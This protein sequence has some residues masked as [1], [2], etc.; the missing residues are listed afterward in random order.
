M[1]LTE[2]LQ[3]KIKEEGPI[4][5]LDFMDM[6]LYYPSLGYYN[7]PAN[8]IGKEGDYYTSP[9]LSS[10]FGEIVAKQLEE[11]WFLLDKKPFTI[12]EYGAG[13]GALCSDILQYLQ[14]NPALF[15]ELKYCIIEKSESMKLQQQKMFPEKVSW[16]NSIEEIGK[17]NGCVLSN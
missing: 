9:V 13:T 11:M 16:F 7:S 8:K 1:Q 17:I 12:I 15:N 6:A 2:I 3:A 5:F 4:S 10:F 14:N